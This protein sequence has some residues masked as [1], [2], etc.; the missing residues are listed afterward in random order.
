MNT[1]TMYLFQNNVTQVTKIR[2]KRCS[3]DLFCHLHLLIQI[4]VFK[5]YGNLGEYNTL[6][7][8]SIYLKQV[9]GNITRY[10]WIVL[11]LKLKETVRY[12]KVKESFISKFF[13]GCDNSPSGTFRLRGGD[14]NLNYTECSTQSEWLIRNKF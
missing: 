14:R 8:V 3:F 12:Q 7:M 11:T 2:T 10:N 5:C 6:A 9:I 4:R 13:P 1:S